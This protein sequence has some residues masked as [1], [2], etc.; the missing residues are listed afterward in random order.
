MLT[1]SIPLLIHVHVSVLANKHTSEAGSSCKLM[2]WIGRRGK[3]I[4]RDGGG[5]EREREVEGKRKRK[6]WRKRERDRERERETERKRERETETEGE[7]KRETYRQTERERKRQTDR[8]RERER[9]RQTYRQTERIQITANYYWPY[10]MYIIHA[11]NN[12]TLPF[13]VLGT[14]N[15]LRNLT[16]GV[17]NHAYIFF[18]CK[19]VDVGFFK[20]IKPSGRVE[21]NAIETSALHW[22]L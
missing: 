11:K 10:Y 2:T 15:S 14:Y 7:R 20:V 13:D 4:R 1:A 17:S 21:H 12:F 3:D 5:R 8:Q 6:K 22:R 9:N 18:I 16:A 19:G